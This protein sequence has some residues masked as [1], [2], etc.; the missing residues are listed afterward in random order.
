MMRILISAC[1]WIAAILHGTSLAAEPISA[2]ALADGL[3][4][5]MTLSADRSERAAK[6]GP[7]IQAYIKAGWLVKK[8]NQRADYTD[9]WVLL[10]PAPFMGQKLIV[11]EEE[12]MSTYVGCC[13][14]EGLG[15]T[16]KAISDLEPLKRF[17]AANG[18]TVNENYDIASELKSVGI[19]RK[20]QK[21][22][23]VNLSCRQRD[24]PK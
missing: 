2:E 13:V 17:A 14:S 5:A 3:K 12:Y 6:S 24:L 23:Y 9:Y 21:A 10:S 20:F 11:I 22:K 16:L 1:V 7:A 4:Q 15:V 8:P 19:V 18:C